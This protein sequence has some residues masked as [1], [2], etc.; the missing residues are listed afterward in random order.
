MRAFASA[1]LVVAVACTAA[2]TPSVASTAPSPGQAIDSSTTVSSSEGQATA[3]GL[4]S[5][6][7]A[8]N[9]GG[10]RFV[11]G[12]GSM[13]SDPVVVELSEAPRWVLA[14]EDDGDV[15]YVVVSE[16]GTV[17]GYRVVDGSAVPVSLNRSSLPPGTPPAAAVGGEGILLLAP[18]PP[19]A[20]TRTNPV[21][22]ELG[23]LAFVADDG[24][25]VVAGAGGN[26]TFEVDA[27]A[28]ARVVES[29]DG[30]LAV[31]TDP[32]NRY[33]HGVLGDTVEASS[34]SIL[35]PIAQTVKHRIDVTPDVIEGIAPLWADLDEDGLDEL[36]VTLSNAQDGARLAVIGESG[37]ITAESEPIGTGN[38]WRH[39]IAVAPFGPQGEVELVEVITPHIGGTVAFRS[40]GGPELA[41]E[42]AVDGY[43]SHVLGSSNLDM[44][45]AA[46][47]DG[48][49]QVELVIP[50]QDRTSMAGVAHT[51][52]GAE[53]VWRVA[54]GARIIT[55]IAA[56][57]IGGELV[58]AIGTDDHRLLIWD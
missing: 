1:A 34:V 56:A 57:H 32:T 19:T 37:A 21:A 28:D 55:N 58:L 6:T 16:S 13:P 35:D 23:G 54:L 12:E 5:V 44:A 20:S 33:P 40:L 4:R 24:S 25:V 7:T 22:L 11:D 27:I 46:D 38:R 50:T 2:P 53:E 9:A 8:N 30:L 43:T 52:R 18:P 42:A 49:G 48:D 39:Q 51:E 45:V 17:E 10:N 14:I 41:R 3:V 29:S 26:R 36:I 47:A 15:T 31:L